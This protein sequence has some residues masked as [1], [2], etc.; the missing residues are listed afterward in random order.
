MTSRMVRCR[1]VSAESADR[2]LRSRSPPGVSLSL[3]RTNVAPSR[4][5]FK[6]VFEACLDVAPVA[7]AK[8]VGGAFYR[9]LCV[10]QF[11]HMFGIRTYYRLRFEQ[12][13]DTSRLEERT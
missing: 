7:A 8:V 6:H 2:E 13:I 10:Q 1:C 3:I 12:V 5:D 9:R 11:D 4:P